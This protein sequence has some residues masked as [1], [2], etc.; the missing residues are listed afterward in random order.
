LQ[1]NHGCV[2][3][4]SKNGA[5][6]V[7]SGATQFADI[8]DPMIFRFPSHF[9]RMKKGMIAIVQPTGATFCVLIKLLELYDNDIL[10][11]WELRN[12]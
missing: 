2:D 3:L 1:P 11:Q 8:T 5:V 4:L 9:A 12:D 6:R 7:A 10:F